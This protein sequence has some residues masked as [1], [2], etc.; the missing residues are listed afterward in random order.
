VERFFGLI[1]EKAIRRGSFGNVKELVGRI[2]HLV[3]PYNKHRRPFVWTATANST[4]RKARKTFL[5][6]SGTRH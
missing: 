1:T 2:D 6:I 5:R 3:T 4:L